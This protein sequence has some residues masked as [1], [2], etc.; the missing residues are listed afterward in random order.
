[1]SG[2]PEM[3]VYGGKRYGQYYGP[4]RL[5]VIGKANQSAFFGYNHTNAAGDGDL[6]DMENLGSDEYPL[7]A[8]RR[9]RYLKTTLT[10]PY[11]LLALDKLAWVDGTGFYYDGVRRGTVTAGIKTMLAMSY[12]ILIFP[13]KKYFRTGALGYYADLTAL[14]ATVTDPGY[15]DIYGIGSGYPYDLYY[16]DGGAWTFVMAEFGGLESS[17]T[18]GA[19]DISFISATLYAEDAEANTIE[20]A[21]VDWA[22]YF[23]EDDAVTVSGCA[24][25]PDNNQTQII[26]EISSVERDSVTYYQLRFYENVFD[27]P[28]Q[29]VY[30]VGEDGLAYRDD[31][32]DIAYYF[33]DG[34]GVYHRFTLTADLEDGDTITWDG[35]GA[36]VTVV[37]N[38]SSST[39]SLTETVG[40]AKLTFSLTPVDYTEPGAVT[41]ARSLPE[42][43]HACVSENRLWTCHNKT[44]WASKLGDPFNFNYFDVTSAGTS[45]STDAWSVDVLTDGSFSGCITYLGYPTFFKPGE[46]IK[47]YGTEPDNFQTMPSATLGVMAGCGR[48]LAIAGE[49][50]FYLNVNGVAAYQGGIPAVI[51]A[52]FGRQDFKNA[53]GGTDGLK[54]YISMQDEDDA[55]HLFVYDTRYG[56]WHREDDTE[57]IAM[58]WMDKLYLLDAGG[59]LWSHAKSAG[60]AEA[61]FDWMAEWADFYDDTLSKKG[62]SKIQLRI[63]VAAGAS[64]E[65]FIQYDSGGVWERVARIPPGLKQM[66]CLPVTPRRADHYR[67]KLTGSGTVRLYGL[68]RNEYEGSEL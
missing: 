60:A 25:Y 45:V 18:S 51:S 59:A 35:S 33:K 41:I 29:Y 65:L 4:R 21:V 53:A 20:S 47:I 68:T 58:A 9:T 56:L 11:G 27:T 15:G 63:E 46:I 67:L 36:T 43:D 61:A 50:L 1:M 13:D 23:R 28:E 62:L 19:G 10:A 26:R 24:S 5:G 55:W 32:N 16:W 52:N 37:A 12:Y 44:I 38:V 2:L 6:Y 64:A 54:Y 7:L 66:Y 8:P 3:S 49:T 34:D 40:D 22:D 17:Y 48:S 57:A 14:S 31:D 42:I 39:R 30:T